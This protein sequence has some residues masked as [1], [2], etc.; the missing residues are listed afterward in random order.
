M[1]R[2]HACMADAR[3]LILDG[4]IGELQTVEASFSF[5]LENKTDVRLNAGWGGGGLLDVGCYCVN[6]CRYFFDGMPLAVTA[7][8]CLHPEHNVDMALHGVLEFS[9]ARHGVISCGFNGGRR[10]RMI[11]CGTHGTLTLPAG[12]GVSQQA[13]SL[14]LDSPEGRREFTYEPVDVYR[15]QI[16]DFARAV[17]GAAP[18]LPAEDGWHNAL[19]MDALLESARAGGGRRAVST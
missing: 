13:V 7:L 9:G 14:L 6:A 12:F 11:V 2:H 16:E 10:N 5:L 17:R 15:A 1:Y 3:K 19:V 18:L 8:G 4:A